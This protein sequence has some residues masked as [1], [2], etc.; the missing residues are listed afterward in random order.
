MRLITVSDMRE[1]LGLS[2][3]DD[4]SDML[5]ASMIADAMAYARA[6]CRLKETECVPDYLLSQMVMEDF[7]RMD[8]AGVK[9]RAVSGVTETYLSGYSDGVMRQLSAMRHPASVREAIV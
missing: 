6:F 9:S 3:E 5:L 8:G 4:T 7:G 1:R 2:P